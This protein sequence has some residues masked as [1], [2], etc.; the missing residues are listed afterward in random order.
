MLQR[1][2]SLRQAGI[3]GCKLLNADG[4]VQTSSIMKFPRIVDTLFQV[5]CLRLRWPKFWGIG[6]L[7]S[8]DLE[9]AEVETIS[10]ACMLMKRDVFEKVGMFSTDYFM[11]SED[12]DLCY[13]LS[14]EG[15]KNYYVG[16]ATI[17]HYGG[18]SS[19]PEWQTVMKTKAE[20]LFCEKRYGHFYGFM[21]R[22]TSALNALA[23]LTLIAML[24]FVR[25]VVPDRDRLE[26][27]SARWSATLRT[28]LNHWRVAPDSFA[29]R[30]RGCQIVLDQ[31]A[32]SESPLNI[33]TTF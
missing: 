15:F 22:I 11:Y 5:E 2:Q 16:Q 12:V 28:L 9:P 32:D 8:A 21:F 18:R 13:K 4:S 27:A 33:K 19:A 31:T 25:T 17:V 30:Q 20:L 6:P 7:F 14:R 29:E 23:R 26:S 24:R 1:L 10:G 3:V